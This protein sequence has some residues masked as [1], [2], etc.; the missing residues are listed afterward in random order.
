M[1]RAV[2]FLAALVIWLLPVAASAAPPCTSPA[3]M[4]T[5]INIGNRRGIAVY[6]YSSTFLSGSREMS[7]CA[8]VA[9]TNRGNV[10]VTYTVEWL[11]F[12]NFW[13]TV[14]TYEAQ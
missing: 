9:S 7:Y 1:D 13:V 6:G 12:G 2:T 10:A 8:A 11:N 4:R 3:V 14:R 5:L